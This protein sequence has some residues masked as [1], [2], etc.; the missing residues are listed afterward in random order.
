MKAFLAV[1][2]LI[3]LAVIGFFVYAITSPVEDSVPVPQQ[4]QQRPRS[5]QT[6]NITMDV[7]PNAAIS[8]PETKG[9]TLDAESQLALWDSEHA[10]FEIERRF[11]PAFCAA[12]RAGETKNLVARFTDAFEGAVLTSDDW[13]ESSH[14]PFRQVTRNSDETADADADVVV[15]AL[16]EQ[17]AQVEVLRSVSFEV[18]S[19]ARSGDIGWDC[20]LLMQSKG[21]TGE[22]RGEL[23]V[24]IESRHKVSF[25]FEEDK[26]L[27]SGP[28][29]SAWSILSQERHSTDAVISEV[30]PGLG[31]HLSL[32]EFDN[33]V[34]KQV[35]GQ[36]DLNPIDIPPL[37]AQVAVADFDNDGDA[38]ILI[39]TEKKRILLQNDNLRFRN[40]TRKFGIQ[41][42]LTLSME[43]PPCLWFDMDNDGDL[44][45]LSGTDLFRNEGEEFVDCGRESGL[46][47][48]IRPSS[49]SVCDYDLDGVLD[50]YVTYQ[51]PPQSGKWYEDNAKSIPN[52]LWR[53]LGDGQFEDETEL[54]NAGGGAAASTGAIWFFANDDHYPD[55]VIANELDEA[56]LLINKG[57]GT[58][59]D[60]SSDGWTGRATGFTGGV[61]A[62]DIDNDGQ[63]DLYFSGLHS[64]IANRVLGSVNPAV[65]KPDVFEKLKDLCSGSRLLSG[66]RGAFDNITSDANVAQVGW[67]WGATMLDFDSDGLLDI[68][69]TSGY[70]SM[71]PGAPG[72][73]SSRWRRIATVPDV[74]Q[75]PLPKIGMVD[76]ELDEIWAITTSFANRVQYNLAAFERNRLFLNKDGREFMDVTMVVSMANPSDSR[77]AIP[78]DLNQDGAVDLV[79]A[80]AG[81]G[82]VIGF[83][84]KMSQGHR[85][86]IRLVGK[87]SNRFGIGSRITANIADRKIVRDVFPVNGL[88]GTGSSDVHI[89]TA[90][91]SK[92][93]SLTVRWPTGEV[94][95]FE[96]VDTNRVIEITEGQPDFKVISMFADTDTNE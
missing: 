96:N 24:Y 41:E 36:L 74:I 53:G 30:V 47:Y 28:V 2:L 72:C 25:E 4:P 31:H 22:S 83:I 33:W 89:G 90:D 84:N 7:G 17:H 12:L 39:T 61:T 81:G 44:D 38:D 54:A 91:A 63:S 82:P 62:G 34:S 93:D 87:T 71:R 52:Q 10:A 65:Y 85:L 18:T 51:G 69:A 15:T 3:V 92:V 11:G 48:T 75:R 5:G 64:R 77:A 13:V 68:Y 16:I 42:A 43:A 80:S 21:D 40:V 66:S 1:C 79:V 35:P 73:D 59:E 20:E 78:A 76:E 49:V 6:R 14:G 45:L 70:R 57:D 67:A 8:A 29:I 46:K 55:L 95:T 19:I 56:T 27:N 86:A 58:F 32:M 88:M 26:D 50:L 23:P 37:T 94:Q 9:V 60:A